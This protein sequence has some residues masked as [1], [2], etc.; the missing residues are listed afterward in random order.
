MQD[1]HP[2]T[3]EQIAELRVKFASLPNLQRCREQTLPDDLWE[4]SMPVAVLL[5]AIAIELAVY[6][7]IMWL[8][9]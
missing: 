1:L 9:L 4:D 8:C 3:A 2:I 5:G 6:F 7:A